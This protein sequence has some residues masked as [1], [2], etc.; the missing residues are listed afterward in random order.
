MK[1]TVQILLYVLIT[2]VVQSQSTKDL[3]LPAANL[4][5][6]ATGS[7]VIPMD[8]ILQLNA[9][10]NFNLR[11][12]GLVIHLLN[13][14]V[15]LKWVIKAGKSKNG[16]DFAGTAEKILP[17]FT[18]A[19][20]CNFIAGP[21]VIA[22]ADTTGVAALVQAFYTNNSLS[23]NDR[24]SVYKLTAAAMNVD[25]R[26]DLSGFI[27]KVAIL[28]DGGNAAV[29]T[30]YIQ[31]AAVPSGNY[32]IAIA[33]DLFS[34]CYTFASEPHADTNAISSSKIN[35]V[36]AFV[37][38]GG[39]FLAQCEA[40]LSYENRSNGYF[41]TTTGIVKDNTN[42]ASS[43]LAYPNA[44]LSFSQFQGDFSI[45]QGGS[46]KNW[47]LVA[48]GAYKN[49]AH[50]HANN[51]TGSVPVGASVSKLNSS[52]NAG[53]LVFYIGNHDFSSTTSYPSI[54]GI[55]MYMNAVLTPV[56][57]NLDCSIGSTRMYVLPLK[58]E[59]FTVIQ[60]DG[61][62]EL[63]WLSYNLSLAPRYIIEVSEDER[64]FHQTGVVTSGTAD[65]GSAA[66]MVYTFREPIRAAKGSLLY[67]RLRSEDNNGHS[68]Y[69]QVRV[70][71]VAGNFDFV[72]V[73]PNPVASQ[74]EISLPVNWMG[75]PI[76]Y[77][78]V[79]LN[80]KK[81]FRFEGSVNSRIQQFNIRNIGKGYYMMHIS[82]AGEQVHKSILKN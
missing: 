29:H 72:N 8:N 34:K 6:L 74:L 3:P 28:N 44:D 54:N 25:I 11:S 76:V 45:S 61:Y 35:A 77:E 46:I 81:L 73:F 17:S 70:L 57:L 67:Y 37:T 1:T 53:G 56:S 62:A 82:C 22:A 51:T 48:F 32:Q 59:K 27:P 18:A 52:A 10:G 31:K 58:T 13:N 9:S 40:V 55:R 33:T 75:K 4:Q 80:G 38:Y 64:T 19:A 14:N 79:D 50:N 71:K 21:F 60:K 24:P 5:T 20:A 23:G 66:E 30:G 78:L 63:S 15:K 12:Y 65:T 41:Q 16:I 42:I 69:S 2:L 43:S 68:E 49:N 47:Q 39:N 26:Y 36:K 7:Y